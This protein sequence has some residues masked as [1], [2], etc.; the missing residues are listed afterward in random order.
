MLS[1]LKW[2]DILGEFRSICEISSLRFTVYLWADCQIF[3]FFHPMKNIG[4]YAHSVY[5][6]ILD[7]TIKI[8][9]QK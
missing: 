8:N 3:F 5:L 7:R 4:F 6:E 9:K 2:L 1:E